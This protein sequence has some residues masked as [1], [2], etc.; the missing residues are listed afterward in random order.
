MGNHQMGVQLKRNFTVAIFTLLNV[1][2]SAELAFIQKLYK[3]KDTAVFFFFILLICIIQFPS[4]SKFN[5]SS[6]LGLCKPEEN[7]PG[8]VMA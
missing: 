1:L 5:S 8:K 7:H 4:I 3:C 6:S 2:N